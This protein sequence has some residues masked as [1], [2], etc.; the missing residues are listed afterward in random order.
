MDFDLRFSEKRNHRL[1]RHG[2]HCVFHA[3]RPLSPAWSG[4]PVHADPAGS[5]GAKRRKIFRL[6]Y[7]IVGCQISS[8][9]AHFFA[10]WFTRQIWAYLFALKNPNGKSRF[11]K[12]AEIWSGIQLGDCFGVSEDDITIS[13]IRKLS[14][15][16]HEHM[17]LKE[18][19]VTNAAIW[20]PFLRLIVSNFA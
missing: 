8:F 7:L 4:H 1:G 12:D 10:H 11:N 19:E 17:S 16:Q 6:S 15:W 2:D 13:I 5:V 9:L 18:G 3:I 20:S 14:E